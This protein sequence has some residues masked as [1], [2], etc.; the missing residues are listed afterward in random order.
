[1]TT[2]TDVEIDNHPPSHGECGICRQIAAQAKR[3]NALERRL[4][5]AVAFV[6]RYFKEVPL[7]NQPYLMAQAVDLFLKECRK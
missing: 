2:L 6:E 5:V 1:M 7:G 3:A 4:A